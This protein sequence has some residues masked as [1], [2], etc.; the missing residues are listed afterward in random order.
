VR[1]PAASDAMQK[2]VAKHAFTLLTR[3]IPF[4]TQQNRN[5]GAD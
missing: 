1:H 2:T 3:T 4:V 5:L